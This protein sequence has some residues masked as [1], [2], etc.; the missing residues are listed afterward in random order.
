M[1]AQLLDLMEHGHGK[2]HRQHVPSILRET[3]GVDDSYQ[4]TFTSWAVTNKGF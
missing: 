1:T 3:P 2:T 4:E